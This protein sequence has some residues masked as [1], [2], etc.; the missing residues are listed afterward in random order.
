MPDAVRSLANLQIA[1]KLV[2]D[3]WH[4]LPLPREIKALL[5]QMLRSGCADLL[6]SFA[7]KD[8][9][10]VTWGHTVNYLPVSS[11]Y[12]ASD[13]NRPTT[14]RYHFVDF[15]LEEQGQVCDQRLYDLISQKYTLAKAQATKG[16]PA[17]VLM[18]VLGFTDIASA[19]QH[20]EALTLIK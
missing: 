19:R 6:V 15:Q 17:A 4:R 9:D 1:T 14:L 2:A 12:Q 5:D 20:A 3:Q 18:S 11:G 16:K 7:V 10:K 8:G 13:R